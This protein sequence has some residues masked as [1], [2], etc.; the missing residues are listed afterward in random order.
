[1]GANRDEMRAAIRD[2]KEKMR[3]SQ[4]EME[5]AIGN[6]CSAQTDF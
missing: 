2:G 3:T 6:F 4:E 1:M 5:T